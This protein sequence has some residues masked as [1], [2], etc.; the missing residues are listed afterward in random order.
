MTVLPARGG[1]P[2][3]RWARPF[4]ALCSVLLVSVV[5]LAA[6]PA[7][8]AAAPNP[9]S[10]R[11][12]SV[13][14]RIEL[15]EQGLAR[16]RIDLVF[17]AGTTPLDGPVIQVPRRVEADEDDGHRR[18]R[19]I[20]TSD[21]NVTSSTG[22]STELRSDRTLDKRLY[23]IGSRNARVTGVQHYT[24][25][26]TVSG[27]VTPGSGLDTFA[28]PIVLD[29]GPAWGRLAA[30]VVAPADARDGDCTS[31]GAATCQV[32]TA[33]TVTRFSAQDVAA[34]DTLTIRTHYR[35]GS[36]RDVDESYTIVKTL[37]DRFALDG[38]DLGGA[39][40][41][42]VI[43]AGAVL[44]YV[45]LASRDHR[46]ASPVPGTIPPPS[47][48][49]VVRGVARHLPRRS[50]P[51][52]ARPAEVGMLIDA[53]PE[54]A[55]ITATMLDL[56]VRGFMTIHRE[57]DHAWTFRRTT[58]EAGSLELYE[59]TVLKKMF[60]KVKGRI[61]T[62][63]STQ[64]ICNTKGGFLTTMEGIERRMTE[65]GW[66]RVAPNKART[67]CRAIGTVVGLSGLLSVVPF[68][69]LLDLG[70]WSVAITMIGLL[71]LAVIPFMPSRTPV[72]SAVRE[73][74]L[75]FRSF[76]ADLDPDS[77]D[78]VE[79]GNI[80]GR[81]LPW[82]VTFGV[83]KAWIDRFQELTDEGRYRPKFV[84]YEGLSASPRRDQ[85]ELEA[86]N[87]LVTDFSFALALAARYASTGAAE[88][89]TTP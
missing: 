32:V 47:G 17:D 81:Y 9:A 54:F 82:T 83:S 65:L 52:D 31:T 35:Q 36:F 21:V 59:R 13:D 11:F 64:Q 69:G 67:R 72:G 75:G 43:G 29:D 44:T 88:D 16:V 22:A 7:R 86:L 61:V 45:I 14:E 60:P 50:C 76:L 27:L 71:I 26:M 5:L 18:Y 49:R 56:A 40:V 3:S 62:V 74:A 2:R 37:A 66:F 85:G 24:I 48:T 78:W 41:I 34:G 10:G 4:C 84:W 15:D 57:E 80:F 55:H 38:L 70:L 87:H 46:W 73:Q 58:K 79:S 77:V 1:A 30:V 51:P 19:M 25:T 12:V 33:G 39:V 68:A 20:E 28:W 89:T 53:R 6:A 63:T 8:A 23:R 42:L